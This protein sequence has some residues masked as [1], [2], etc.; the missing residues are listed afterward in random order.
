LQSQSFRDFEIILVDNASTDESLEFVIAQYPEVRTVCNNANDGFAKGNNIGYQYAK[1]EYILLLNNDTEVEPDL[2]SNLLDA[3]NERPEVGAAQAKLILL[4]DP[5]RLDSCG[6][7]FTSTSMLYHFGYGKDASLE[8]YSRPRQMFSNQGSCLMLRRAV[9]DKVGLFD[10]DFWCYY[11]ETDLCHRIW[12]A[13]WECWYWPAAIC[14]HA[15]GGTALSIDS[16]VLHYHNYKNKLASLLKNF[17]V[18]SLLWVL[19]MYFVTSLVAVI[20]LTLKRDVSHGLA[21][22]H[23]VYWV[24]TAI[25][26][27]LK[28]RRK[29]QETRR[30]RDREIF[31][32]TLRNPRI[33][34]YF[35]I[36]GDLRNYQ[37]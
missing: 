5:D 19:P 2:I 35:F 10:E 30:V 13:G 6:S 29:V 11:E 21:F 28:K 15:Q 9:I 16:N 20:V 12:L 33:V 3:F 27:I 24:L 8:L 36:A 18:W 7:Y 37:D 22:L 31:R 14:K 26:E 17:S 32:R 34:Y 23:G 4:N 25:P 1:G